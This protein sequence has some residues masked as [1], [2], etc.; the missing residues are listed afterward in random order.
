MEPKKRTALAWKLFKFHIIT[1][2]ALLAL[3][4]IS[5]YLFY[6]QINLYDESILECLENEDSTRAHLCLQKEPPKQIETY[7]TLSRIF[8]VMFIISLIT[9]LIKYIKNRHKLT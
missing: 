5:V 3:T 7:L 1:I 9:Y 2:L 8:M 4:T 6:H